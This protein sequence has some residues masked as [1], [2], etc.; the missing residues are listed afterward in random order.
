MSDDPQEQGDASVSDHSASNNDEGLSSRVAAIETKLDQL[1]NTLNAN[2]EWEKTQTLEQAFQPGKNNVANL[3][4]LG[5]VVLTASIVGK[6]AQHSIHEHSR[7]ESRLPPWDSKSE[8]AAIYSV[9]LQLETQFEMG[10]RINDILTKDY[11]Q[12]GVVDTQMAGPY[13]FSHALF[14]M[15]QCLIHHPFLLY[16]QSRARGVKAPASFLNR[17]LQTCRENANAISALIQ[18]TRSAG[19]PVYFSFMGYCVTVTAG[20]HMLCLQTKDSG[21]HQLSTYYLQSDMAFLEEF[22]RYWKSGQTMLATLQRYASQI[23]LYGTLV[24]TSPELE[25]LDANELEN[26]WATVDYSSMSQNT[27]ADTSP[28]SS[29]LPSQSCNFLFGLYSEQSSNPN[30]FDRL[31]F[32]SASNS[33]SN[34]LV[35]FNHAAFGDMSSVNSFFASSPFNF[36]G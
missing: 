14:H 11:L 17:S 33:L 1:M 4:H 26:L 6:C 25:N 28:T 29:K 15:S 23:S 7:E 16:N 32:P 3:G 34:D 36:G 20:I 18:D 31:N 8:F 35:P 5:L 21:I 19:Y 24:T 9:L 30:S 22:S 12:D 27:K 10:G 2:G 13:V